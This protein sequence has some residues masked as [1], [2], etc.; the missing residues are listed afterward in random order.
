MSADALSILL[1]EDDPLSRQ[2]LQS[3]LERSGH[4]VTAV[5]NGRESIEA[6]A[7]TPFDLVILDVMMPE[8]NGMEACKVLKGQMQDRWVPVM[9]ISSNNEEQDQVMGMDVG[10][11]Y[12]LTKPISF[13]LLVAKLRA[14]QRIANL[15]RQLEERNRQLSAYYRSSRAE[16]ELAQQ[17][18][19]RIMHNSA[20]S[21]TRIHQSVRSLEQFSGDVVSVV[22]SHSGN[23]YA[24]LAD[25][26]GHGLPAAITL[27]PAMEIFYQM[28]RRG[29]GVPSI[30]RQM[31]LRLKER[32][33]A[34]QFLAAM[35]ALVN[36]QRHSLQI[37]NGGCPT[38]YVLDPEGHINHQLPSAHPPLGVLEDSLFEDA[39][40]L[41]TVAHY[42]RLVACSDGLVEA[43]NETGE[44]FGSGRLVRLLQECTLE[45]PIMERVNGALA[46]FRGSV[47]PDDDQSLL[48]L[49]VEPPSEARIAADTPFNGHVRGHNRDHN[50]LAGWDFRIELRGAEVA[51][52]EIVPTVNQVLE[53]LRL[54]AQL[55]ARAFVVLTEL[56][57]NAVDHGVL[58]LESVSKQEKDGFED[59]MSRREELLQTLD[60]GFIK[61][62][63]TRGHHDGE[64][65]VRFMV[66]DSGSG[67]NTADFATFASDPERDR[68]P[69]GRGIQL[70]A[71]LVD[72]L[73]FLDNGATAEVEFVI[74]Q[75]EPS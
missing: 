28:S 62:L 64:S 22:N 46:E 23:T 39:T 72:S 48:V 2:L 3:Y 1:A 4:S 61:V 65:R 32:L 34:N 21:D 9:M 41:C 7:R 56:I 59:Y 15:H 14:S 29:Y 71:S 19:E 63:A 43:R 51:H 47:A 69:H 17:M 66:M 49:S 8:T 12:Y 31:N 42:D 50:A 53:N 18:I 57:N 35:V 75:S 30:V 40:T 36:P 24:L 60:Q 54:P 25:A 5:E 44:M 67:F 38:A 33:P 10:A 26:T 13:P 11:D 68:F 74:P 70:V 16:N 45:T 27:L 6:F 55:R 58:G 20:T 73:Q 37:W 52:T